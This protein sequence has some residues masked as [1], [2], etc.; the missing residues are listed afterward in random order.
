VAG[1]G[2]GRGVD[3]GAGEYELELLD[4]AGI[5]WGSLAG[6]LG[7]ERP[8]P[9]VY[10]PRTTEAGGVAVCAGAVCVGVEDN[11]TREA[12]QGLCP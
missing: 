8:A 4:G 1:A 5:R 7:T 10:W 11:G 9:E 12:P 6:R 2:A 3:A